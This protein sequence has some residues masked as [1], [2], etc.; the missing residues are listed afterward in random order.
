MKA[1]NQATIRRGYLLF[2]VGLATS[3]FIAIFT[4]FCFIRTA[5]HETVKISE[6]TGEYDQIYLNQLKMAEKVDSLY[7]YFLL[8]NSSE[9]LN[10]TVLQRVVSTRKMQ[11]L[12]ALDSMEPGDVLLYRKLASRINEF[13]D[14]REAIRKVYEEE[15]IVKEDLLRCIQDNKQAARQL[16][17]GTSGT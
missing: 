9:Q 3:V 8:L 14:I 4:L 12:D 17:T 6:K 10:Q 7:N 2:S 16:S 5:S 11:L 1:K 13:L 15:R